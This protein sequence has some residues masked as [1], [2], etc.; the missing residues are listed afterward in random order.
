M[1]S[2]F[3]DYLTRMELHG[4]TKRE[5]V[6]TRAADYLTRRLPGS[7]SY[8]EVEIEGRIVPLTVLSTE[9]SDIK[10]VLSMPGEILPHGELVYWADNY[11]LITEVDPDDELYS[12]G[13]MQQCNFLLKWKKENGDIVER[14]SIV[15]DGTKYLIG[16]TSQAMMTVGNA[17]IAVT[18]G[19]DDETVNINRGMRFI[20]DDPDTSESLAY[21]VTKPNKMFNVYNGKGVIRFIM[22]EVSSTELD[23]M[24]LR[25]AD[26]Y[27]PTGKPIAGPPADVA[28]G[29]WI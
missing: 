29:V 4:T 22:N 10:K 25:I 9:D 7:L 24:E 16:E 17:R 21:Q 13:K 28:G 2:P 12:K 1:G 14:W 26:Y 15:E 8:K 3:D 20:I 11:W 23:N 27:S 6:K 19:R 18:V 5:A